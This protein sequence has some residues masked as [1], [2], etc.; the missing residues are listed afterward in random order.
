MVRALASRQCDPGSNPDV[1]AICELNLLLV[2]SL[3]SRDFFPGTLVFP[4]PSKPT[5][6]N[7]NSICNARKRFDK[8]LQ[9]LLSAAWV[10][11]LQ[12]SL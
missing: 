7:S 9:E 10:N 4:S 12:F 2:L 1:D 11:K 3:D 5:L 8:F 6:P